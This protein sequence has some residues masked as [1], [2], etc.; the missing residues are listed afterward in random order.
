MEI[1]MIHKINYVENALLVVF[2]VQNLLIAYNVII[3]KFW[4][5]IKKLVVLNVTLGSI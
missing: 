1:V 3:K 5:V 4:L 2:L